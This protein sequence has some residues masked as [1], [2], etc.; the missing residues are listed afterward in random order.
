MIICFSTIYSTILPSKIFKKKGGKYYSI[1]Y[2]GG[3][4]MAR[5][6]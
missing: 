5:I 3:V 4:V 1:N 2:S 6:F